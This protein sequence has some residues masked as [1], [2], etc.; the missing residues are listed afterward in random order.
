MIEATAIFSLIGAVSWVTFYQL[1]ASMLFLQMFVVLT[2]ASRLGP[3]G[4]AGGVLIVA[5]V[6]GLSF[7]V[8]PHTQA[9]FGTGLRG[10]SLYFQFYL[11]TLFAASL[12]IA[13]LLAER[14]RILARLGEE[15]RLLQL[16]EDNADIGHWWLDVDTQTIRW[17]RGVFTIFG[18]TEGSPPPLAAAIDAYHPDD[19]YIVT[20]H[21][22]KAIKD[23]QGFEF[24]ARI[25]RPDGQ[26]RHVRSRGEL[27]HHSDR[28][29]MGL[30]GIVQ[31]VTQQVTHELSII[32]ARSRAEEAAHSAKIL[33]ETDQLTQIPNRRRVTSDLKKAVMTSKNEGNPVSVALFDIDHFKQVNDTFGHHIG[34][35]VLRRVAETATAAV[36]AC[37]IVGRFGGEEFVILLPNTTA[38]TAMLI[39][40]R[41]RIAIANV[42]STPAVTISVGVAERFQEENVESLLQRVDQALYTAKREG[43]NTLSLAA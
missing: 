41:V 19:R 6:G 3:L 28:D 17:S 10:K 14:D 25:I 40:E 15:K 12:P 31:D 1:D 33:A 7:D 21:I 13:A 30:F 29:R 43:R 16:A 11:L 9:F 36:R 32:E 18:L 4:A 2:A 38:K 26:V 5:C 24:R 34:D 37:D 22:E 20:H 8:W 35:D 39:A 23:R 42:R 27:D